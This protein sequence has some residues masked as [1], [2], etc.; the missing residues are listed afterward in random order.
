M[1]KILSLVAI[2]AFLFSCGTP[3]KKTNDEVNALTIKALMENIDQYVGQ[4]V[5]VTGMVGHVCNHGGDKMFLVCKDTDLKL[6]V[7]PSGELKS[8]DPEMEG[9]ICNA[10]GIIE[11]FKIDE[12]YLAKW[13]K[14]IAEKEGEEHEHSVEAEKV[15]DGEHKG[16]CEQ[17]KN[18][19]EQL[20]S[21][22]KGYISLYTLKASKVEIVENTDTEEATDQVSD[23]AQEQ[24]QEQELAQE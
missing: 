20:A 8:F 3:Q 18:Y 7:E 9:S 4:T 13:E 15:V 14:E 21:S 2:T 6:K 1:K 11:E 16:D 5:T 10:T 12:E 23:E 19:R 22:E 24:E 17:I